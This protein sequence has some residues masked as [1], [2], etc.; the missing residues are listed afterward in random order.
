[1]RGF[2]GAEQGV[3]VIHAQLLLDLLDLAEV[4]FIEI[5]QRRLEIPRAATADRLR[6][7]QM[8]GNGGIG[9]RPGSGDPVPAGPFHRLMGPS[10]DE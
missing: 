8:G 10:L 7:Q 5:E 4:D 3:G 2:G 6:A 9:Q 1:M